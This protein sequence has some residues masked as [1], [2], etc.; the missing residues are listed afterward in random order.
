MVWHV[1]GPVEGCPL[2]L[3][4]VH[5]RGERLSDVVGSCLL[6]KVEQGQLLVAVVTGSG[7]DAQL[8]QS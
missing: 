4:L 7:D 2:L 5:D 6:E 1:P 8:V 3:R